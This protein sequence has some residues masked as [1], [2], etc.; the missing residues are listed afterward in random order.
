MDTEPTENTP[1]TEPVQPESLPPELSGFET[2]GIQ[3]S[4]PISVDRWRG[5]LRQTE[6]QDNRQKL[7]ARPW[8]AWGVGLLLLVQN[9]GL[10]FLIVW[11]LHRG[12]LT[13]LQWIFGTL[14]GG[15]L[16][17]SY[18]LLKLIVRQIFGDINYH[19]SENNNDR[20]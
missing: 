8:I 14:I 12:Q 1:P 19:N 20:E 17:E 13:E 5:I 9:V 2:K 16:T 11:A 18:F 6:V 4:T 10:W 3:Y 15:T 7:R